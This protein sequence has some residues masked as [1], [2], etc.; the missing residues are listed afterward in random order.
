MIW[1]FFLNLDMNRDYTRLRCYMII[2][3]NV[4]CSESELLECIKFFSWKS[5]FKYAKYENH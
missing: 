5:V 1:F 4:Q 3:D 2:R